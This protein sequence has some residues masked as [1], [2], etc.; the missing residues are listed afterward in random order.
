MPIVTVELVGDELR[1]REPS[2]AQSLAD[3][4]AKA[5]RSP[6][7]QT[8][9]RLRWISHEDYAENETRVTFD[10][11]PV[12]VTVLKRLPPAGS[13]LQVEVALLTQA[14]ANEVG[15]PPQLVHVEYAPSAAGRV[16]FGGK[17][18]Q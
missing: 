10:E 12:F 1:G 17:L 11:F 15:R 13:E 4:I 7:G 2:L 6:P 5:L 14:I 9:V 18:V 3:V 8:W 16:S